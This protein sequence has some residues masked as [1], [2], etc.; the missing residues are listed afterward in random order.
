M[1]GG[2]YGMT[3]TNPVSLSATAD[4]EL[5]GRIDLSWSP[6]SGGGTVNGYILQYRSA[7]TA[8]PIWLP[9][10]LSSSYIQDDNGTL[11]TSDV[12]G[13]SGATVSY[14][15][16]AIYDGGGS[17]DWGYASAT[18][19]PVAS[20]DSISLQATAVS[21]NEIDLTWNGPAD[22]PDADPPTQWILGIQMGTAPGP[23]GSGTNS[24]AS[25]HGTDWVQNQDGTG[26]FRVLNLQPGTHYY[27]AIYGTELIG[28][29]DGNVAY[30]SASA[31]ATTTGTNAT[32][33][34]APQF[35][36]ATYDPSV[37]KGQV[38]LAWANNS[39]NETG[40]KVYRSNNGGAYSLLTTVN[41]DTTTYTDK[42]L[43]SN[44][45]WTY[46][47]VAT[48]SA[49]DSAATAVG[50]QAIG[51]PD[52]TAHLIAIRS[53]FLLWYSKLTPAQKTQF[54]DEWISSVFQ[55]IW[56]HEFNGGNKADTQSG[57]W[58]IV[59]LHASQVHTTHNQGV[60]P[61]LPNATSTVTV[62]GHVYIQNY[63]NYWLYGVIGDTLGWDESKVLFLIANRDAGNMSAADGHMAW[64]EAGY[65]NNL[66]RPVSFQWHDDYANVDYDYQPIPNVGPARRHP[67]AR[68]RAP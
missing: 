3:L 43:P 36:K 52:I 29:P 31:D 12:A 60:L 16:A 30:G 32:V 46:K 61:V 54:S 6:P 55:L 2:S 10:D 20:V 39:S 4:E 27:F 33:P 38:K 58:D 48:N 1:D 65:Q 25:S 42:S 26:S 50:V 56:D 15:M 21:D 17:S 45:P 63:V 23:D 44:G 22:H 57:N 8:G 62:A 64:F 18:A 49:G 28:W 41:A 19:N 34:Q 59:L 40:F 37:E 66:Q 68:I 14:R 51:G 53:D 67:M 7:Y 47:V 24:D 5:P 11:S 9:W 13:G 35:L